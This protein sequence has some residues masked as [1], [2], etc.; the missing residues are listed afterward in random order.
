MCFFNISL[1]VDTDEDLEILT[2]H[3][4]TQQAKDKKNVFSFD[5][6]VFPKKLMIK[7]RHTKLLIDGVNFFVKG[8][9]NCGLLRIIAFKDRKPTKISITDHLSFFPNVFLNGHLIFRRGDIQQR[10]NNAIRLPL[11][12]D[13]FVSFS[14]ERM[15]FFFVWERGV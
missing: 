7:K 11:R 3:F 1:C 12:S 15:N 9:N 14:N 8:L 5:G 10:H 6:I 13:I 4:A 2:K